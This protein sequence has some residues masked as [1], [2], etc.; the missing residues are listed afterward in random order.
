MIAHGIETTVDIVVAEIADGDSRGRG[1]GVP[2][3]RYGESLDSVVAAIDAMK[4]AV[5]SGLNRDTLQHAMPRATRST[6]PSGP[7]RPTALIAASRTWPG[8]AR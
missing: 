6:A 2:L 1:E 3:R 7:S 4:G 5:S 8:L